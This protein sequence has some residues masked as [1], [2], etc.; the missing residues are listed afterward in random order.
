MLSPMHFSPECLAKTPGPDA[1]PKPNQSPILVKPNAKIP[2]LCRYAP[3]IENCLRE[4]FS[5]R[6]NPQICGMGLGSGSAI[7][8]IRIQDFWGCTNN[9]R[10]KPHIKWLVRCE[11]LE[12]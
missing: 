9:E 6:L 10:M 4:G 2:A 8:R 3:S 11:W 12:A 7:L 5:E 1:D